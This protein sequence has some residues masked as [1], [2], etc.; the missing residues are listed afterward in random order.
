MDL[1]WKWKIWKET[2]M[3]AYDTYLGFMPLLRLASTFWLAISDT[4]GWIGLI[5][6]IVW[7]RSRNELTENI[8]YPW[9]VLGSNWFK[10]NSIFKQNAY[11]LMFITYRI[12]LRNFPLPKKKKISIMKQKIFMHMHIKTE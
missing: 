5:T 1:L 6:E 4:F 10:I 11:W 3:H 9:F 2:C 7:P 12:V 8:K